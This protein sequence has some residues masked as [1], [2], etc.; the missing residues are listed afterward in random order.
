MKLLFCLIH[1]I[2]LLLYH[3]LLFTINVALKNHVDSQNK[4]INV[5]KLINHLM[6][7]Q[8]TNENSKYYISI[9]IL[10]IYIQTKQK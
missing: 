3:Y 8:I 5:N 7:C 10:F 4:L 6:T 9:R 1:V 2:K